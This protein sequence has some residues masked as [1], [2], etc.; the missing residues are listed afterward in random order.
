[1]PGYEC[2]L[3]DWTQVL[4]FPCHWATSRLPTLAETDMDLADSPSSLPP[5]RVRQ[6]GFY[7]PGA[8]G[9]GQSF[10]DFSTI[11]L[12]ISETEKEKA[13][14]RR[15]VTSAPLLAQCFP[16]QISAVPMPLG[17]QFPGCNQATAWNL[18]IWMEPSVLCM[19]SYSK[20]SWIKP[21]A[22]QE[23]DVHITRELI[24]AAPLPLTRY[25]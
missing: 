25:D 10:S 4:R 18:P 7:N 1:M 22:I 21:C 13:R 20:L 6:T 19:Q 24:C 8:E 9:R 11:F 14:S 2:F 12:L 15:Q 17:V 16:V 3:W 23:C 5:G